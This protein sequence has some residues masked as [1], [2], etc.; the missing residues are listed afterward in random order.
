MAQ[1]ALDVLPDEA[2]AVHGGVG[3]AVHGND[4]AREVGFQRAGLLDGDR[5]GLNAAF[6][7]GGNPVRLEFG[8]V[9]GGTDEEALGFLDAVFADAPEDAVFLDALASR[10]GVLH[11]VAC[12]AVEQAVKARAGA[13]N[14]V[15]LFEQQRLDPAHG[16]VAKRARARGPADHDDVPAPSGIF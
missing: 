7:A 3:H 4:V 15:T 2:E 12:A 10:V 16:E 1:G 5:R 14:E 6:G 13:V 8:S 9:L 11:G